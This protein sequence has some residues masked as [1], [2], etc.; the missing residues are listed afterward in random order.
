M[1]KVLSLLLIFSLLTALGSAQKEE[2]EKI[3]G[4]KIG[5]TLLDPTHIDPGDTVN[6]NVQIESIG[7]GAA[8]DLIVWIEPKDA[9]T[10]K[11]AKILKSREVIGFA[12]VGSVY[13]PMFR[14]QFDYETRTGV[15]EFDVF[16]S[17]ADFNGKIY[18]VKKTVWLPVF[19]QARFEIKDVKTIPNDCEP[20]ST[21]TLYL[22]IKNTGSSTARDLRVEFNSP[23]PSPQS[24]SGF[25]ITNMANL[26]SGISLMPEKTCPP[27]PKASLPLTSS[28]SQQI[29]VSTSEIIKPIGS[30]SRFIGSL[31]AGE[32]KTITFR[33]FVDNS[34]Q[35]NSYVVPI[36][37]RYEEESE[38]AVHQQEIVQESKSRT[39]TRT[40]QIE[41]Q[42]QIEI[43]RVGVRVKGIPDL[44]IANVMTDPKQIRIGYDYATIELDIENNGKGPAESVRAE[45]IPVY[46]FKPSW[47]MTNIANIGLLEPGATKSAKFT[48]DVAEDARAGTYEVPLI[49]TFKERDGTEHEV[50]HTINIM[51]KGK[52]RFELFDIKTDPAKVKAGE[53]VRLSFKIKNTGS[54]QAESVDVRVIKKA[55]QPFD[56]EERSDFIGTLDPN[57]V[58]EGSLTFTV[59]DNADIK[60][61]LLKIKINCAG[62]KEEGDINV[63]TYEK[64]IPVE[65]VGKKLRISGILL[66]FLVI[67]LAGGYGYYYVRKRKEKESEA[68]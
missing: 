66:L 13:F 50:N 10:A 18:T 4:I 40:R 14:I 5:S 28:A 24:T 37:L 20:G 3:P 19:G 36:L 45:L 54:E 48:V 68:E 53:K 65:V 59:K 9:E 1:R 11:H 17:Y 23:A 51:L 33:F 16:A 46:P 61:Y 35:D 22:T 67:L 34:A 56:F 15:Y 43:M 63:Y 30:A 2:K 39:I 60:K 32:E 12:G 47:S 41:N 58:G 38:A 6:L 64:S 57:D 44:A 27:C 25:E 29:S 21:A 26:L 52:P 49:L 8:Y 62:D 7:D 31:R 42:E 55:D